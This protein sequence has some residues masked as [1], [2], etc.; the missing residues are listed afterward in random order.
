LRTDPIFYVQVI[1]SFCLRKI[2]NGRIASAAK[3]STD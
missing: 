1:K 2:R 3:L